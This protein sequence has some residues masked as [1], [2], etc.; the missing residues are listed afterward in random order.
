MND[1]N[2]KYT[3]NDLVKRYPELKVC[4]NDIKSAFD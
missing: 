3:V 1:D 4:S 2:F